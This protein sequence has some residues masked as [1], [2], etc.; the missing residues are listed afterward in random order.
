MSS[1]RVRFQP[2][3][4]IPEH[5]PRITHQELPDSRRRAKSK[6]G[7]RQCKT[8]RVKCDETFPVCLRCRRQGLICSSTPA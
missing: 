8:K 3:I 5:E 4:C 7:C 2:I 6:L 1:F